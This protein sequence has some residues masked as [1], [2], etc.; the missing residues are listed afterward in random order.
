MSS[1]S[2][3]K[4]FLEVMERLA[5]VIKG[6]ILSPP[7]GDDA[8]SSRG[9]LRIQNNGTVTDNVNDAL[10]PVF[11]LRLE[12]NLVSFE[13]KLDEVLQ[14]RNDRN[15]D[16][17]F[18]RDMEQFPK[19]QIS[20]HD[21]KKMYRGGRKDPNFFVMEFDVASCFEN[22][23]AGAKKGDILRFTFDDRA[24]F[25]F[26]LKINFSGMQAKS[27]IPFTHPRTNLYFALQFN[28]RDLYCMP[29]FDFEDTL[30]PVS[31][32]RDVSTVVQFLYRAGIKHE[33]CNICAQSLPLDVL[34]PCGHTMCRHCTSK[35][36]TH[37][38]YC[39]TRIHSVKNMSAIAKRCQF[40][41]CGCDMMQT[42]ALPCC[43]LV[44]CMKACK[45]YHE[46]TCPVCKQPVSVFS[47]CFR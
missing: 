17:I 43:C 2:R 4:S 19:L 8:L 3:S 13:M 39:N 38:P 30:N 9:G 12:S 22:P 36:T 34:F 6:Q 29:D 42:I 33:D 46:E 44:G 18:L 47:Y 5:D 35:I 24:N 21:A 45:E 26:N 28:F 31:S 14:C 41:G 10:I 32:L 7:R 23:P 27:A 40:P 20:N 25:G 37:C 15:V 16:I 1:G 11:P